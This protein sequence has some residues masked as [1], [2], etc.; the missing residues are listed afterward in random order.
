MQRLRTRDQALN[1]PDPDIERFG[2]HFVASPR[3]ADLLLV[4][5]PVTRNMELALKR[6]MPP[7]PIQS[8]LSRWV[9]AASA[10]GSSG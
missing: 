9:H 3:H 7:R 4:T 2:I 8:W 6:P 5:G 10:A 1:N